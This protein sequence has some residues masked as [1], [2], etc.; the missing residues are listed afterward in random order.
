MCFR[1]EKT[2]LHPIDLQV[3]PDERAKQ[4]LIDLA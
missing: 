4:A 2:R 3:K 1:A